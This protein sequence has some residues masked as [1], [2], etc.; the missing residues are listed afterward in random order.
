[1]CENTMDTKNEIVMRN[2]M[3]Y[4]LFD[5]I[6]SEARLFISWEFFE[7]AA[8]E[9]LKKIKQYEQKNK[10][11]FDSIYAVPRGGLCLGA[12]LAYLMNLPVIL[13]KN[14]ITQKT[15]IADDCTD[16]GKTLQELKNKHKSVT[17]AMFHKPTSVFNPDIFFHET[18]KQI[19]FCWESKEERN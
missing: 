13:D 16:T 18:D 14:K 7:Q 15:L 10:I 11:K 6:N 5:E 12:K 17:L 1:M 19:N 9:L 3:E 8:E 4:T 2:M